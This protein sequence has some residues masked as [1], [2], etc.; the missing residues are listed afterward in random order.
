MKN[1]RK[2]PMRL[3]I[4][5]LI[6]VCMAS[7]CAQETADAEQVGT[8]TQTQEWG[9]TSLSPQAD[10][11]QAPEGKLSFVVAPLAGRPGS[12]SWD[13]LE[14]APLF[15]RTQARI[16]VAKERFPRCGVSGAV[17]ATVRPDAGEVTFVTLSEGDE[18]ARYGT[19]QV[20][21]DAKSVKI[22][23][24]SIGNDCKE[25]DS[26][27]GRGYV[28]PVYQWAPAA[29]RFFKEGPAQRRG[30]LQAGGALI[31]DYDLD[32]LSQCRAVYRGFPSWDLI[33]HARFD[34]KTAMQQSLRQFNYTPEGVPDGTVSSLLA[35]FA[36][37][38]NAKNVELWFEN[39]QYPSTCV[40]W[41][42]QSG[43][44]YRFEVG[45]T[46]SPDRRV[47]SCNQGALVVDK[48]GSEYV[49][50]V[51]D[52]RVITHFVN[53]SQK[54]YV[55]SGEY[56]TT[57]YSQEVQKT[58]PWQAKVDGEGA[59]RKL[60][61]TDLRAYDDGVRFLT[62]GPPGTSLE[63][64]G[65]GFKLEIRGMKALSSHVVSYYDVG[66]WVF[67]RCVRQ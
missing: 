48:Q 17:T 42:S 2:G 21:S 51:T 64:V 7:G 13:E 62:S 14:D 31:V 58:L 4:G 49:A 20:P 44:N 27:F 29:V 63:P 61:V 8:S 30:D 46:T 28:F 50:T 11:L 59:S 36:I 65:Q 66:N 52:Q 41:D 9:V 38:Y 3:G 33:A 6:F 12:A 18:S 55:A 5:W 34:G 39:S 56:S 19:F 54:T 23:L 15:A 67:D 35:V 43:R 47:L 25:E 22:T 10:L 53:E 37:P 45:A 1:G 26:E 40:A 24:E 57:A 60:V 32:R 16:L